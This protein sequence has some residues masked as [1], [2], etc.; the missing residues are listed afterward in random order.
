MKIQYFSD[1]SDNLDS[2]ASRIMVGKP[3]LGGT[4]LCSIIFKNTLAL[5][6]QKNN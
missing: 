5:P 4:G 2:P 1:C 3:C 6:K